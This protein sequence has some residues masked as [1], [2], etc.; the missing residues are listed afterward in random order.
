MTT[1]TNI[2]TATCDPIEMYM[3]ADFWPADDFDFGTNAPRVRAWLLARIEA[4]IPTDYGYLTA[5]YDEDQVTLTKYDRNCSIIAEVKFYA[6]D[7]E[8][9]PDTQ[10]A[11]CAVAAVWS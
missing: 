6:G 7:G 8:C 2:Q 10:A 3:D 9:P 11:F 5:G 1:A 4:I